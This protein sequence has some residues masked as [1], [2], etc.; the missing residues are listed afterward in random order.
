MAFPRFE[1]ALV[2][3]PG[4]GVHRL[5]HSANTMTW[6]QSLYVKFLSYHIAKSLIYAF[7]VSIQPLYITQSCKGMHATHEIVLYL[8]T[9]RFKNVPS[10]KVKSKYSNANCFYIHKVAHHQYC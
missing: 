10:E 2:I 8:A 9:R 4:P 6:L 3:C 5:N 7:W 1:P